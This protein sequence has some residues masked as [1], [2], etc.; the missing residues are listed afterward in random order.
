MSGTISMKKKIVFLLTISRVFVA[1]LL[2]ILLLDPQEALLIWICFA[3]I[4]LSDVLDGQLAR[5]WGV[6]SDTGKLLDPFCDV[7]SRVGLLFVL[8]LAG[9]VPAI[10]VLLIFY[11]EV[12]MMGFRLIMVQQQKVIG[13]NSGGKLKAVAYTLTV[14]VGLYALLHGKLQHIVTLLTWISVGLSWGSLLYYIFRSTWR[15]GG[16]GKAR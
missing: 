12:G 14:G 7:L 4:E 6:A 9:I 13:A 16:S 8:A 1:F 10:A 2:F 3:F 11:R 15:A 5:W